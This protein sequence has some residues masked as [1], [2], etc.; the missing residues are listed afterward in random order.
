MNIPWSHDL[1]N[2]A[3]KIRRILSAYPHLVWTIANNLQYDLNLLKHVLQNV[4]EILFMNEIN[5]SYKS[6]SNNV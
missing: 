3:K 4:T 6:L 5:V 1:I 2:H